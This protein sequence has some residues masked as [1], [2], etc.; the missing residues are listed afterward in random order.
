MTVKLLFESAAYKKA[1]QKELLHMSNEF[2]NV[3]SPLA[4]LLPAKL[5]E[6]AEPTQASLSS[7][8]L[9]TVA[10]PSATLHN[11]IHR[12]PVYFA[13]YHPFPGQAFNEELMEETMFENIGQG[14][15]DVGF[16]CRPGLIRMGFPKYGETHDIGVVVKAKV[17]REGAMEFEP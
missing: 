13:L 7:M 16:I 5:E 17:L 9:T 6:G 15:G 2:T 3:L 12:D 1:V 14:R 10:A 8:V 4:S 11:L